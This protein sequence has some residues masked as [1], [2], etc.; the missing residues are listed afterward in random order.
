MNPLEDDES[1]SRRGF[2][3]GT[4]GTVAAAG[5]SATATAQEDGNETGNETSGGGDGNE[6][7][8][9]GGGGGGATETV[10]VIDNEFQPAELAVTPG[11]TVEF[12]WQ[13][14]S[15]DHNVSPTSQPEGANWEGHTDL[16]S[17]DFSFESTFDTEGDYEYQCDPHVG[18]GMTGTITVSADAA[19]GGGGP[20]QIVPDAAWTLVIAT[21]AGMLS[22]LSLVYFF[23]RYGGASAE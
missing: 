23:M 22:T 7:S 5:A 20:I 2:L 18:L 6:T 16:E 10:E 19:S 21:V 3:V 12:A 17:G 15:A 11:T 13:A 8:G 4:A 14:T 9:G 1:L